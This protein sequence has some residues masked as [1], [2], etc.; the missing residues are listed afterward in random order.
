MPKNLLK[1]ANPQISCWTTL[2][3]TGSLQYVL[4]RKELK[5]NMSKI[6][7]RYFPCLSRV[8]CYPCL[9][10][11]SIQRLS[12]L[13]LTRN[14][15]LIDNHSEAFRAAANI[16]ID[17]N[18]TEIQRLLASVIYWM[19]LWIIIGILL[20]II[21]IDGILLKNELTKKKIIVGVSVQTKGFSNVVLPR[22]NSGTIGNR[23]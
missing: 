1:S 21:F 6:S 20:C 9:L 12:A 4:S 18:I 15:M 23:W 3:P 8:V 2:L 10:P 19:V 14:E 17:I 13:A 22:N 16:D 5:A 7:P 11:R